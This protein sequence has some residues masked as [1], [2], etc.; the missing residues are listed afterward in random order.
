MQLAQRVRAKACMKKRRGGT[1]EREPFPEPVEG[2]VTAQRNRVQMEEDVEVDEW[3]GRTFR[4]Y[5]FGERFVAYDVTLDLHR[6][7][8]VVRPEDLEV[9]DAED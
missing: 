1:W 6:R 8:L 3:S 4:Y 5:S 9:L 2:I 7:P